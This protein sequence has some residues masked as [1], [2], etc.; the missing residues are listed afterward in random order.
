[1]RLIARDVA[2]MGRGHAILGRNLDNL[3]IPLRIQQ[4]VD[5]DVRGRHD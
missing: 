3:S 5:M 4:S 2:G 1:M